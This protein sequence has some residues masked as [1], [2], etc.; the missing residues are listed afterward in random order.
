MEPSAQI[1]P[2]T[3]GAEGRAGKDERSSGKEGEGKNGCKMGWGGNLG[4]G[5]GK[6]ALCQGAVAPESVPVAGQDHW[7]IHRDLCVVAFLEGQ[8]AGS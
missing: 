2:S 3:F 5:N 7:N 1:N 6:A 8:K 4:T